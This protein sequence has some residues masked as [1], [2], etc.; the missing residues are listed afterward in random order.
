[1]SI[2]PKQ[3]SV[4]VL[5]GS[6]LALPDLGCQVVFGDFDIEA[7]GGMSSAGGSAGNSGESLGGSTQ[8]SCDEGKYQ[9]LDTTLRKCVDGSW[10]T[11]KTCDKATYCDEGRGVCLTCLQ[12]EYHCDGQ[13]LQTCNASQDGWGDNTQCDDTQI[14]DADLKA[15]AACARGA[16]R[17]TDDQTREYCNSDQTGWTTQSCPLG[18]VDVSGD[19]DY[20]T[21]C[22]VADEQ[23]C[24]TSTGTLR[25]CVDR[26]WV[27]LEECGAGLCVDNGTED[28]C[29]STSTD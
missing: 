12:G 28:Y 10:Q 22:T 20:C 13:M 19:A 16:S 24:A 29:L 17:C 14:C 4:F 3:L 8:V 6:L 5:A 7:A 18:C 27:L 15:C 23:N 21:Q 11:F 1:M 9:C 2:T 25:I 26:K